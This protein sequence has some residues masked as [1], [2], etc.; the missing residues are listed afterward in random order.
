MLPLPPRKLEAT[1]KWNFRPFL[2]LRCLGTWQKHQ[3]SIVTVINWNRTVVVSTNACSNG[4]ST[5]PLPGLLLR[6][7]S[8]LL[9]LC[10]ISLIIRNRFRP[11][12]NY[13]C[14]NNWFETNWEAWNST[15]LT[16]PALSD[17]HNE[18]HIALRRKIF[19]KCHHGWAIKVLSRTLV[20][21]A[22]ITPTLDS[23]SFYDVDHETF[24][25]SPFKFND[26]S[27]FSSLNWTQ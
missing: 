16:E 27:V 1:K 23:I 11:A 10:A 2:H 22:L 26:T 6:H 24:T 21:V 17:G 9:P 4:C 15:H 5:S 18:R 25:P 20:V 8:N 19:A 12:I 3:V 14:H 13:Q 7:L